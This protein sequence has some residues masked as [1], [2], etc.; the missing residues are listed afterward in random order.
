VVDWGEFAAVA[1]ELL[2]GVY[3]SG[4]NNFPEL[5]DW[6][7]C[8][9]VSSCCSLVFFFCGFFNG[10]STALQWLYSSTAL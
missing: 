7:V 4:H 6:C 5:A 10:S 3:R 8:V 2:A 1:G 9:C